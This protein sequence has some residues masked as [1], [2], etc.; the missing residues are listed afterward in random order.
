MTVSK[1]LRAPLVLMTIAGGL[2]LAGACGS[3]D[4]LDAC[5]GQEIA[6]FDAGDC[7]RS[8]GEPNCVQ[9]A[10][11]ASGDHPPACGCDGV[12]YDDFCAATEAGVDLDD[13]GTCALEDG[14]FVCG[15]VQC[16]EGQYCKEQRIGSGRPD[17]DC[18][19]IAANCEPV[20][21]D[22]VTLV[23]SGEVTCSEVDG[24]LFVVITS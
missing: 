1:V 18:G 21:C 7:G 20:S 3:D 13:E 8:G 16:R 2:L 6:R 5:E 17:Y 15:S 11:L 22:C 14:R 9:S 4:P 10:C 19:D 12:L 24:R 23:S